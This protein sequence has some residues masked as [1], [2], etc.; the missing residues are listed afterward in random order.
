[1]FSSGVRYIILS[2]SAFALVNVLV[3]LMP[4][5]PAHEL[6]FFR[7]LISL[8]FCVVHIKILGIAVLGNNKFW[9]V[10]RGLC[11]IVALTLFFLTIKHMPLASATTIQYLSPMFTVIL[12]IFINKQGVKPIQ[13]LFFAIAFAGVILIKGLD[14]RVSI[15]WLVV[16]IISA[17]F[18]ALAYNAII[19]CRNTDHPVV[20]VLYFPLLAIPVMGVWSYFDWVQPAGIEWLMLLGMGVLTQVAQIAMVKAL[21][22]EQASKITPYKYIGSFYAII[23]GFFIFQEKLHWLSMVGI[24]LVVI[25][26]LLNSRVKVQAVKQI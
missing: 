20:V 1:M 2:V 17:F 8:V 26:V 4:R 22:L 18:A 25:G 19:K 24:A 6:I 16:G 13:F 7:S 15:I 21:H 5:I 14:D 23:F 9:L 11:G 12:A 3:K 10:I